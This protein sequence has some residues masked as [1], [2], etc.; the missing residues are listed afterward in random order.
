MEPLKTL[1]PQLGVSDVGLAKACR[2][3]N[4]PIPPR[5]YWAKKRARK[6]AIQTILPPRF[7]DASN[8]IEIGK[9]P[10]GRSSY[11]SSTLLKPP[12]FS[13]TVESVRDRIQK[14][15]GKVSYP[16]IGNDT[17]SLTQS[18]LELDDE[19]R[20]EYEQWQNESR[21]P[22]FNTSVGKRK[23]RILNALFLAMQGAGC[24]PNMNLSKYEA[25][26]DKVNFYMGDLCVCVEIKTLG[27]R[28]KGKLKNK[29]IHLH[30]CVEPYWDS[31]KKAVCWE[32]TEGK[33]I[34]QLLTEIVLEIILEAEIRHREIE[35]AHYNRLVEQK[36]KEEEDERKRQLEVDR[37]AMELKEKKEQA[38][39]DNLLDSANALQNAETIRAFVASIKARSQDI[40]VSKE[41]IEKWA[42]WALAQADRIDPIKNLEFFT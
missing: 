27:N 6:F 17:H 37:L 41:E 16:N 18:L 28:R 5:G 26:F 12:L 31:S 38:C 3:A 24:K 40:P 32:D 36:E 1:A 30:L 15:I 2:K 14:M 10:Y 34:Q 4:V 35:C 33:P 39:I 29:K 8:N 22:L 42:E 9:G 23:L 21:A 13:E 20:E 25:E 11:C 7:P 19:R